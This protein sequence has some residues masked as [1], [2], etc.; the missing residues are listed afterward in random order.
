MLSRKFGVGMGWPRPGCSDSFPSSGSSDQAGAAVSNRRRASTEISPTR[1]GEELL[2]V[3]H[4]FNFHCINPRLS[5]YG[6]SRRS[7]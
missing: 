7:S 3:I 5:T 4:E 2:E 1:H 6:I